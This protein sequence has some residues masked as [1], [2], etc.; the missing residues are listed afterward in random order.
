MATPKGKPIRIFFAMAENLKEGP[1]KGQLHEKGIE[2]GL[3]CVKVYCDVESTPSPA[4]KVK[5]V[6]RKEGVEIKL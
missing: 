3:V 2:R 4:R 5:E 6:L 1:L